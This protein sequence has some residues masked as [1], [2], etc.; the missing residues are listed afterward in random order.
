VTDRMSLGVEAKYFDLG[1][2][3][4]SDPDV[5]SGSADVDLDFWSVI[6]KANLL[7]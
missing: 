2:K 6:V 1:S 4:Y 7:L 5:I 3:T